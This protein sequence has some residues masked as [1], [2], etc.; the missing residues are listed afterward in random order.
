MCHLST[1]NNVIIVAINYLKLHTI[2][3]Q[4]ATRLPHVRLGFIKEHQIWV[5]VLDDY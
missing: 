1:R 3:N 2:T 4:V 5:K